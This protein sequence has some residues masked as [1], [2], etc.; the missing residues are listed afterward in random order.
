MALSHGGEVDGDEVLK[1]YS[2]LPVEQIEF[3]A[4]PTLETVAGIRRGVLFLVAFWSDSAM[5]AFVTLTK[6]LADLDFGNCRFVAADVDGADELRQ[7]QEVGDSLMNGDGK[8]LWICDGKVLAA[9][10]PIDGQWDRL[11]L[12]RHVSDLESG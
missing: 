9:L 2:R 7:V 8:T 12:K 10:K 11:E 5:R 3:V 6:E 1:K 4:D